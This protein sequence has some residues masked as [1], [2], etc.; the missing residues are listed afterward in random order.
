MQSH[1]T[2]R[3]LPLA[4]LLTSVFPSFAHTFVVYFEKDAAALNA[5][6]AQRL[7]DW[8][9][10]MSLKPDV[11]IVLRGHADS[12]AGSSYNLMLSEQRN[13]TVVAMLQS[14][15]LRPKEVRAYGETWPACRGVDEDCL[16]MNRRVEIIILPETTH[17]LDI[18][19]ELSTPQV[20]FGKSSDSLY[21]T[22]TQE[23]QL[24][25]PPGLFVRKDGSVPESYRIEMKEYTKISD[26]ILAGLTTQTHDGKLLETGGMVNIQT[27][28]GADTLSVQANGEFQIL[29]PPMTAEK[30][31][32]MMLFQGII[33]LNLRPIQFRRE[34]VWEVTKKR[35]RIT[36]TIDDGSRPTHPVVDLASLINGTSEGDTVM[37]YN[38]TLVVQ[39]N[40][41]KGLE[42]MALLEP[43]EPRL[44]YTKPYIDVTEY[45]EETKR[46]TAKNMILLSDSSDLVVTRMPTRRLGWFNCDRFINESIRDELVIR[47]IPHK[48]TAVYAILNETASITTAID[49]GK[50]CR[51]LLPENSS[52]YIVSFSHEETGYLF[53]VKPF[54]PE[55]SVVELSPQPIDKKELI[56]QLQR[57]DL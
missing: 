39:Q 52:G 48:Y 57:L 6:E 26:C 25:I 22:G 56:A 44:W 8:L 15:K 2:F 12:D 29:F 20:F 32:N 49:D 34:V 50:V 47:G 42:D 11:V 41:N 37:Y 53:D 36:K 35:T 14:R 30:L 23:T 46:L 51:F 28:S 13:A 18:E 24:E 1:S 38:R 21:C 45:V 10:A 17:P 33:T 5:T 54:T 7:D 9:V 43:C 16:S 19:Q 31:D 40:K 55:N 3:L 27:F 4:L